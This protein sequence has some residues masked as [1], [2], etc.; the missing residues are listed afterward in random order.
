VNLLQHVRVTYP[1][2]SSLS[3]IPYPSACIHL[4]LLYAGTYMFRAVRFKIIADDGTIVLMP[5]EARAVVDEAH[6]S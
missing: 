1:F 5:R 4:Y 6:P 3:R 2:V